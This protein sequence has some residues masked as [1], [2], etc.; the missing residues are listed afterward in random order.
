MPMTA[1]ETLE[2]ARRDQQIELLP[3]VTTGQ[4]TEFQRLVETP[5]MPPEIVELL[6]FA[7]GFESN[8]FGTVDF[9][10]RNMSVETFFR[11]APILADGCGN[12]WIVDLASDEGAWG[13]VLFWSHD[14]AVAV[15]QASNL[16]DFLQQILDVGRAGRPDALTFVRKVSSR[17]IWSDDPYLVP[18]SEARA[19]GDR[20]V[21]AFATTL[22]NSFS[23]ADLRQV[24]IGSGFSW[25]RGDADVRRDGARLLFGVERKKSFIQR[26]TGGACGWK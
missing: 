9:L 19:Q 21:A 16:A 23:V 10:G 6:R 3:P 18:V 15:I 2:A 25:G 14:P 8:A 24:E 17:R 4:L 5:Q 26:L 7:S 13:P 11:S 12:F 22:P 1:R 20:I